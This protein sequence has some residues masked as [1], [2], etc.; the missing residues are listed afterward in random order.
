MNKAKPF[1]ISKEVVWEA[2]KRVK[3]N[4]G[5]AGVDEVTIKEFEGD[6][7]NNL[8]K[9][10]NRILQV[11]SSPDVI[12]YKP[13]VDTMGNPEIQEAERTTRQ[14]DTLDGTDCTSTSTI[15]RPLASGSSSS[16]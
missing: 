8:Y 10:W 4:K 11:S 5:A 3:A 9:L 16:G 1:S 15:V 14:S 13:I 7:K 12:P 6:L 2:Y